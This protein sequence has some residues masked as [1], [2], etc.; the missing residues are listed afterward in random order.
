[1]A[2]TG[3]RSHELTFSE[4]VEAGIDPSEPANQTVY[5]V[6]A[7]LEFSGS[8]TIELKGD[9]D[10]EGEFAGS[11][12]SV[13]NG[14]GEGSGHCNFPPGRNE[15]ETKVIIPQGNGSG[16]SEEVHIIAKPATIETHPVIQWLILRGSAVAVKQFF[17]VS[18]VVQ[19]LSSEEPFGLTAGTATLNLPAGMSLA[20][21]AEAQALDQP[22]EAIP[23]LGSATTHWVIRGDTPGSYTPSVDYNAELEP[24]GTAVS[25]Q[26]ALAQP[27]QVWGANALSTVLKVDSGPAEPGVPYHVT[28]G[29][30]NVSD[31]PLYN[32]SVNTSAPVH[33]HF[34]LQPDQQFATT[35]GELRP[36]QTVSAP[37]YILITQSPKEIYGEITE[38]KL[39]GESYAELQNV[40]LAGEGGG[41][42][43][44]VERVSPPT[45]YEAKPSAAGAG[46]VHLQWGQV[47]GAEGYEVFA[48]SSLGTP[49]GAS[50][51][52]TLPAGAS[53]ANVTGSS[54]EFYAVSTIIAGHLVLDHPLVEAA[55]AER[56][57]KEKE[58][59]EQR[60]KEEEREKERERH[61]HE[62]EAKKEKHLGQHNE[63]EPN[64]T[65]CE[66][67]DS[68][69]CASGNHT[70]TQTDLSVGGRGP[71]LTLTRTYNSQQAVR[72]SK[73]GP[74]G[75]GWTGPYGAYL[76]FSEW[77]ESAHSSCTEANA[78]GGW[79]TVHQANGSTVFFSRQEQHGKKEWVAGPLVQSKLVEEGANLVF[80]LPDG[81]TLTFDTAGHLT[82]QLGPL[83]FFTWTEGTVPISSEADRNGNALTFSYNAAGEMTAIADAAGRK[84]SL[85]YDAEGQVTSAT[86]PMGH[87]VKYGYEH[88]DLTSVTEP[89]ETSAH[90]RFAYNSLGEMTSET[91]GSNP[92][93]TT[94]YDSFHRVISQTDAMGRKRAWRYTT[95]A[96]GPQTTITEPN[97]STTVE[98][99]DDEGSPTS[100]THAY[101]TSLATTSESEYNGQEELV[102]STDPEGDKTT[103]TYDSEGNRTGETDPLGHTS[104][105]TYDGDHEVIGETRPNGETTTITR[106]EHGNE[107]EVSRPAP[108]G[109]T[110]ATKYTYDAA[111][112]MTSMTDALG[113][114][115]TYTYDAYGDRES[116]TD[117]EGDKRTFTYDAD[118]NLTATVSPLGNVAG[119]TASKFE[120]KTER[121]A[122]ERPIKT[123]NPLGHTTKTTYNPDG[124]IAT[125][126]EGN[127][128][129]TT[130]A[131]NA[132]NQPVKVSEADGATRETEY[133]A[134]GQV[135]AQIN[136]DHDKTTYVRNA[137]EQ[138]TE[139]IDPLGRRT[140]KTYDLDGDLASVTDPEGQVTR[141]GYDADRRETKV[142]YSD[143]KTA[144]VE[145]EYDAD[146]N[147]TKM[148]DGS[149]TTTYVHDQLDRLT[150]SVDGHGER[151]AYEYD[152]DDQQTKITYP[153]GQAVT[154]SFDADGRL[155]STTDWMGG[156]TTFSY[157]ADSDQTATVFPHASGDDDAYTYNDAD[158]LT[159]TLVKQGKKTLAQLTYTRAKNGDVTKT[160]TKDLPGEAKTSYVYDAGNRLTKAGTTAYEYDAADNPTKI[161][162]TT[163]TFDAANEL[164][165]TSAGETYT[166]NEEGERTKATPA[167]GPATA[168]TYDQAGDLIAISRPGEGSNKPIEATY[169][170]NGE[171]LR[172]SESDAGQTTYLTWNTAEGVPLLL[173]EGANSYVYGPGGQPIEQISGEGKVLYMHHDE[174][175]STRLLTGATG[176]VEGSSTY[177]AYGDLV[178][179]KGTATTA[180]G[181]DGQYTEPATGLIYLRARSYE[182]ATAQFT[183]VDPA[184]ETTGAPYSYAADD[185]INGG[186]PTGRCNFESIGGA[187]ESINPFSSEN[188]AYKLFQTL[189]GNASAI[190]SITG[191]LAIV[192][193][194]TGVGAPFAAALEAVS[195]AA[196]AYATAEDVADG[197]GL[198]AALDGLGTVLGGEAL[199]YKFLGAVEE[200]AALEAKNLAD[201]TAGEREA[202]QLKGI[203]DAL[204]EAGDY[205]LADTLLERLNAL[206]REGCA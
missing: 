53:S 44:T 47:P 104:K 1:V 62:E 112:D 150:E 98:Q 89:G 169:A 99:F 80:R 4:I 9:V 13:E 143:A 195:V 36:G 46:E 100:V 140:M 7:A 63:S 117:P 171:G 101:G 166:Y 155:A 78:D 17:E 119:A 183:S 22:V 118:S 153:N 54:S 106:D 201:L 123:T 162:T 111:G 75:Y 124:Q 141:Y 198:D 151:T 107:T 34:I 103:F 20:P 163:N 60:R 175:G 168:Y 109:Q 187:L 165:S 91:E 79:V 24:F 12:P 156:T 81:H 130:Y 28:L 61:E 85:S 3:L 132:D 149:G 127:G 174:Q 170:Y 49:F 6:E 177:D 95:T 105:W 67:G 96:S 120:T 161:G 179:S 142:T 137:L 18:M 192:V 71:A 21:T 191:T 158:E 82:S 72:E 65:Q 86:D 52:A 42:P 139:V 8:V 180:L 92:A 136:G 126:T 193:G 186:D 147:R 87:T 5:H 199:A 76:T 125:S 48:T 55:Q 16:A 45:L 50:P 159:K 172:V 181:Y 154:R 11:P 197:K 15:C 194:A 131:Y 51:I 38:G 160:A 110:Q 138:V 35:I 33:N 30:K 146:G 68:V 74:F 204:E 133:D 56:E 41:A 185:P 145:Y 58:E 200:D 116:E 29:V 152:L 182:P 167:S 66:S 31:I 128:N 37:P 83:K 59:E 77:C 70:E 190:S 25:T 206:L 39:I 57:N 176:G 73:P 144:P 40:T 19:N 203:A 64:R 189:G 129:T 164:T 94:E 122:Q 157:N 84:I 14:K 102:S 173:S 121:D 134:A 135:V 26:A 69:N 97:G 178:A 148:V 188:C 114:K 90:W 113:H 108:G 27:L 88:G 2:T 93:S 43:A 10:S 202:A 32:V 196:G 205:D 23:P 184:V 115:W